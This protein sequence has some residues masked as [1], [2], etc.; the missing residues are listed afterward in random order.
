MA[1]DRELLEEIAKAVSGMQSD[2]KHICSDVSGLKTDVYGD[3]QPGLK[4]EVTALKT[5]MQ[6]VMWV[7]ATVGAAAITG[8]VGAIWALIRE[9]Q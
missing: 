9:S 6:L 2:I 7:L 3:G 4:S 1:S 5:R 8:A